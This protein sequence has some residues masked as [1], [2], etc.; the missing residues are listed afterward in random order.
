MNFK[1]F[2]IFLMVVGLG[3]VVTFFVIKE[4]F[5]PP[6]FYDNYKKTLRYEIMDTQGNPREFFREG[7]IQITSM[8]L[9]RDREW[10]EEW[11]ESSDY[12]KRF[13]YIGGVFLV[14]GFGV[15]ISAKK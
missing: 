11:K 15:F 10:Y 2:S 6:D 13:L 4:K 9:K 14:L 3:F 5:D 12:N 8:L 1:R 7:D